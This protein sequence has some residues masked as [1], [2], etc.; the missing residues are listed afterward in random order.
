MLF[1]NKF[2]PLHHHEG[3][4]NGIVAY[5]FDQGNETTATG[6]LYGDK[7]YTGGTTKVTFTPESD[8]EINVI[9]VNGSPLA[10]NGDGTYTLTM[11]SAD[12]TITAVINPYAVT[13][14]DGTNN[15]T[16]ATAI[17]ENHGSIADV[18]ISGRT[19]YK[20]GD[21]N[22]LCLPFDVT[23]AQIAI[24]DHPLHDA[25]IMELDVDGTY[26]DAN[27]DHQ[28]GFDDGT[29]YLYFKDATAIEAG[30]PYLVKWTNDGGTIVNPEFAY[31]EI[32]GHD[33]EA[34]ESTDGK[35]SFIGNFDPVTFTAGEGTYYLGT[36]NQLYYPSTDGRTMN[37]FRAY[38]HV[39]LSNDN[40]GQANVRAFSLHFGGNDETTGIVDVRR[41]MEDVRSDG[42]YDLHGRKLAT[43]PTTKGIYMYN[44]VKVV[45]K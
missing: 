39:D 34:I 26:S 9:Q 6:L 33:P 22:T 14:Y 18:T 24:E 10:G 38:F 37:A 19:L 42:W 29:L 8:K 36:N 21:W 4:Y 27:G 40:G 17:D 31:S 5:S 7:L 16:N 15:P 20:D 43:K 32:E 2:V 44:G 12:V 1:P 23:A 3:D 45:I 35:V 41:N 11:A 25:T 13:L 28:T 30:V